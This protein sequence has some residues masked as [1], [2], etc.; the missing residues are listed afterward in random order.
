MTSFIKYNNVNSTKVNA[1]GF[2]KFNLLMEEMKID[3]INKGLPTNARAHKMFFLPPCNKACRK[4]S[5]RTL[6]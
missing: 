6:T 2:F 3:E 1:N 4:S 5:L